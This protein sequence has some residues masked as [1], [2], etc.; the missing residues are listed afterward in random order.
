MLISPSHI[1]TLL[2]SLLSSQRGPEGPHTALL[3]LPQGQLISSA[4]ADLDDEG[5]ESDAGEEGEEG[6]GDGGVDGDGGE[7]EDEEPYLERPERLRLLLGLASQWNEGESQKMECELGRLHFT[8]ISLPLNDGNTTTSNV[9]MNYLPAV[10]PPVVDRFVLVLNGT[11]RTGW[12]T[13]SAK[14]EGFKK[15]WKA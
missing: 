13:L 9:N 7:D 4:F 12:A 6:E 5:E 15:G 3:I 14:S 11:T 1:H 2:S 10:R 8:S